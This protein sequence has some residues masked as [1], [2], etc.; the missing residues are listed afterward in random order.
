ME[1]THNVAT[2][3]LVTATD[4]CAM[5]CEVD[6]G[7][8]RF[9]FENADSRLQLDFDWPGFARFMRVA[10]TI[11][12]R[13]RAIPNGAPIEFEVTAN[14]DRDADIITALR[15]TTDKDNKWSLAACPSLPENPTQGPRAEEDEQHVPASLTTHTAVTVNGNGALKCEVLPDQIELRF[16]DNNSGLQFFLNY[17]GFA[18]F[19]TVATT[20]VKQLQ[21]LPDDTYINFKVWDDNNSP[22]AL[23]SATRQS[24]ED[25]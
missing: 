24:P 25:G 23:T 6:S 20:V 18:K 15:M 7:E 5:S 9:H 21:A 17:Q 12:G 4:R 10:A 13:L 14:D 3:V 22:D 11:I 19:M 8:T 1:P 16:G 2:D